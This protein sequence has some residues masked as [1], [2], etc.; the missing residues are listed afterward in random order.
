M[1]TTGVLTGV[2]GWP[3][4]APDRLLTWMAMLAQA[5]R[6]GPRLRAAREAR[7]LGLNEAARRARVSQAALSQYERSLAAPGLAAAER[8]AAV[9]G[10]EVGELLRKP[11]HAHRHRQEGPCS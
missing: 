2:R 9:C 3:L 8:L 6:F 1:P 11:A 10:V 4:V 7:G 5:S